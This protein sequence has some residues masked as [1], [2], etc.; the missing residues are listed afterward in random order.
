MRF[1][2]N[3]VIYND[4]TMLN[5]CDLHTHTIF[6]MHGMS[7]PTEMVEAAIKFGLKYI[8][9]TDHHYVWPNTYPYVDGVRNGTFFIR[10]NQEAR[11]WEYG[12]SFSRV[13][14]QIT[15]IPGYEYN[16][17]ACNEHSECSYND[18]KRS[19][20]SYS[21]MKLI[22]LHNWYYDSHAVDKARLLSEIDENLMWGGYH[23]FTHPEREIDKLDIQGLSGIEYVLGRIVDLCETYGVILEVNESSLRNTNHRT[24]EYTFRYSFMKYWLE[25]AKKKGMMVVVNSDAHSIYDIGQCDEAFKLL[26]DVDYPAELIINF[27]EK[28]IKDLLDKIHKG[29]A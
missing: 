5:L 7:S 10:K 29:G 12:R 22:G 1:P 26:E 13:A 15:V 14:D 11:M 16:F 25:K 23:I 28:K 8:G 6:S 2:S 9:L 21:H 3:V 18:I 17:F 24:S 27:D 4:K 20:I 19:S